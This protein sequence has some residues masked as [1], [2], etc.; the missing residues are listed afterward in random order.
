MANRKSG[1]RRRQ[2]QQRQKAENKAPRSK[3][4]EPRS[5][6][7]LGQNRP[8]RQSTGVRITTELGKVPEGEFEVTQTVVRRPGPDRPSIGYVPMSGTRQRR[9]TV[10]RI[11]LGAGGG[12]LVGAGALRINPGPPIH[13]AYAGLSADLPSS[14][15]VGLVPVL[16]AI[17]WRK[18]IIRWRPESSS[19]S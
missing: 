18:S 3:G 4:R 11:A 14:A 8:A 17:F 15:L 5:Q 19:G 16:L 7:D 2:P 13:L 12:P 10:T 1:R 9:G 6:V